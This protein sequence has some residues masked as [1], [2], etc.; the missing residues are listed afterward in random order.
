MLRELKSTLSVTQNGASYTG[1]FKPEVLTETVVQIAELF[2]VDVTSV[3]PKDFV[4]DIKIAEDGTVSFE[5]NLKKEDIPLFVYAM[6]YVL[7]SRENENPDETDDA[8]ED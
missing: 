5:P 8:E 6:I 1:Q 4:I 2:K 7:Q 3:E